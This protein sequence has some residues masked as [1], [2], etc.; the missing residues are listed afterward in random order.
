MRS[1]HTW[2]MEP[3]AAVRAAAD[4]G[5]YGAVIRLCRRERG[6]SQ[7]QLGALCGYSQ[8]AVSRL[9]RGLRRFDIPTLRAVARALEIPLHMFG[10]GEPPAVN[11]REFIGA[12]VATVGTTKLPRVPSEAAD[13]FTTQLA[14]HWRADR[15]LGPHLLLDT[16]TQQTRT[17]VRAAAATRGQLHKDLL[18]IAT[19]YAGLV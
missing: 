13:Y 4:S 3:G 5:D 18:G 1:A 14:G 19:A 11:R 8:S 6:F 17:V 15:A 12:V 7:G 10:L 16:V 2:A 9:E